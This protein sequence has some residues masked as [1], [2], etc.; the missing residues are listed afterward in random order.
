MSSDNFKIGNIEYVTSGSLTFGD[1]VGAG[2][3]GLS[4]I[5]VICDEQ[6][7]D[8]EQVSYERLNYAIEKSQGKTVYDLDEGVLDWLLKDRPA[9]LRAYG[10]YGYEQ[11]FIRKDVDEEYEYTKRLDNYPALSEDEMC[12]VEMEWEQEAWNDWLKSDLIRAIDNDELRDK[13]ED[14]SDEVLREAYS[15]AMEDTNTYPEAE[16]NGVHV[17]IDRIVDVFEEYLADLLK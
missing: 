13:A 5:R 12:T 7:S 8:C 1:Y 4:N 10:S 2:S 11:V 9:V 6:S 14:A 15:K 17:D 3:V 16:Y